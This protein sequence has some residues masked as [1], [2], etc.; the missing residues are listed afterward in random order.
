ML[1]YAN[2]IRVI[3][4]FDI[5][6]F[7]HLQITRADLSLCLS[8]TDYFHVT[9]DK[10]FANAFLDRDVIGPPP[11][12]PGPYMKVQVRCVIWEEKTGVQY[13]QTNVVH[14][15]ILDQDDNPPRVQGSTSISISLQDF[16]E[17][18]LRRSAKSSQCW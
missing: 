10:L 15:D 9:D 18:R 3:T 8:G 5:C 14:I 1:I 16:T 12:G 17:V 6:R 2:D 7:S 4:R 13:A 11:K